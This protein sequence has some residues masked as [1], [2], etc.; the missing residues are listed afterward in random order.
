VLDE[1][2][3]ITVSIEHI[4]ILALGFLFATFWEINTTGIL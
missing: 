4:Y 3:T 1:P 2:E